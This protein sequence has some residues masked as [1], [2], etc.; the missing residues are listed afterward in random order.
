MLCKTRKDSEPKEAQGKG[1]QA[2]GGTDDSA[3]KGKGKAGK[4]DG[5]GTCTY[6][7]ARHIL[8]EKQGKINEAYKKLEDGWL[9]NGDNVPPAEFA[10][11]VQEYLDC[12][13]G[14]RGGFKMVSAGFGGD[15]SINKARDNPKLY[16]GIRSTAVH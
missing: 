3:S 16:T 8:C 7:Q 12:P 13:S 5:L 14:K 9:S 11:I 2:G 15:D 4:G 10:K 1:K 6:V